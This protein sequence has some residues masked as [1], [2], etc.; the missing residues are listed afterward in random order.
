MTDKAIEAVARAICRA[1]WGHIRGFE[2]HRDEYE[3]TARSL[4]TLY[5]GIKGLIEGTHVAARREPTE[6]IAAAMS[7]EAERNNKSALGFFADIYRVA[8]L[9]AAEGKP[10]D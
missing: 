9:A 6:A 3:R 5:P 4:I 8:M 1:Q 7:D 10:H 2:T